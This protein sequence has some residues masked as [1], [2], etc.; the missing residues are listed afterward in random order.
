M[1]LSSINSSQAPLPLGA[2]TSQQ[3]TLFANLNL[4][5]TQ[6]SQIQQIINTAQSQGLS[7]SKVQSNINALL[8]P[9]QQATLASNLASAGTP[10]SHHSHQRAG[11]ASDAVSAAGDTDEFGIPT[12][13]PS[14][15]STNAIGNIAS[16]FAARSQLASSDD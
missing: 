3:Q 10:H 16:A 8:T 14:N 7:E 2:A 15:G 13:L 5:S 6:A 4:T 1:S 9:A 12:R 11:K